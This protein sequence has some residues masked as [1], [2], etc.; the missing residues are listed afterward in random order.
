MM[1]ELACGKKAKS[2]KGFGVQSMSVAEMKQFIKEKGTD[3]AKAALKAVKGVP[4]RGDLCV[5][6]HSFRAG[7]AE[8]A[9]GEGVMNFRLTPS[10]NRARVRAALRSMSSPNMSPNKTLRVFAFMEGK[11]KRNLG[12]VLRAFP[13][14]NKLN[15]LKTKR[16]Y[17]YGPMVL[18]QKRDRR[19]VAPSIPE[20]PANSNS[21]S[22]YSKNYFNKKN[23]SNSNYSTNNNQS[24]RNGGNNYIGKGNVHFVHGGF[25]KNKRVVKKK[26][27][28]RFNIMLPA[29]LAQKVKAG[30]KLVRMPALPGSNSPK[31]LRSPPPLKM[32]VFP[33]TGKLMRKPTRSVPG[34]KARFSNVQLKNAAR[35]RAVNY[36]KSVNKDMSPAQK[37]MLA[38]RLFQASIK[39]V[40]GSSNS[41]ESPTMKRVKN[42]KLRLMQK[43]KRMER[44]KLPKTN[45]AK[46]FA[47]TSIKANRAVD[48]Q[49]Y[50]FP[51]TSAK[52]IK[53]LR[54][55]YATMMTA[56]NLI[57]I[58]NKKNKM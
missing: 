37:S 36:R 7:R 8:I 35:E 19:L 49:E 23:V 9:K 22:N 34:T 44:R 58:K 42:V 40:M 14:K 30:N 27:V 47:R 10:P 21:N 53:E 2:T 33:R 41:N 31:R 20:A 56:A 18:T 57:Q 32:Q 5:I 1:K 39:K 29:F 3:G 13:R 43:L 16:E 4:S 52:N 45:L 25:N 46:M 26:E 11:K 51:R 24:N 12:R 15:Y 28:S 55:R 38:N 17:P 6:F 48:N 50:G 54:E